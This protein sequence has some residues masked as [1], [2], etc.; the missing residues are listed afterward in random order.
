MK[1]RMVIHKVS[2][3]PIICPITQCLRLDNECQ[4]SDGDD[5]CLTDI[6]VGD[7]EVK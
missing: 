4:E 1:R 3:L 6:D 5:A 7:K 2:Y